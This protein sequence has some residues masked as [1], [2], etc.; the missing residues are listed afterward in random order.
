MPI[1]LLLLGGGFAIT[2]SIAFWR[3]QNKTEPNKNKPI[4]TTQHQTLSASHELQTRQRIQET[5]HGLVVSSVAMGVT[6]YARL[7]YAPLLWV[8][9]PLTLYSSISIFSDTL[10]GLLNKRKFRSSV[11]D[12][13][14]VVGTLASGYYFAAT[15]IN[16]IHFLGQKLL[17]KT[18]D[19]ARKKF[20]QLFNQQPR[21]VCLWQEDV[22]I[23]VSYESIEAGDL[24]VINTG[25]II[26][27][28]GKIEAG[29][30]S[31]DQQMLTGQA[32]PQEKTIGDSVLATTLLTTG[33]LRIQVEKAGRDTVAAHIDQRLINTADYKASVEA[34]SVTTADKLTWPTLALSGVAL[35]TLGPVSAITVVTCN[36][37]NAVLIIPPLGVLNYMKLADQQGILIKD[38]RSLELLNQVDTIVFDK[39]G[40]L[41]LKQ[42]EVKHIHSWQD[43]DAQGIL[44]LAATAEH[45]QSHPAARAIQQAASTSGLELPETDH[46]AY[47]AGYGIKG[48]IDGKT[49]HVGGLR[50]MAMETMIV[51][52]VVEQIEKDGHLNG[53]SLVYVAVDGEISG[54]VELQAS[55]R[56]EAG[57]LILALRQRGL[58]IYIMSGD[59]EKPTQKIAE[60]LAIP[61]FFADML[62]ED[63]AR[64]IE[65]LQAEGKSVCFIGDGLNDTIAMKKAQV[66]ISFSGAST[67][68][69]HTADIV[70]MENNLEKLDSLLDF[71][72]DF[73]KDVR[74]NSA[75]ALA[76]GALS[77]AGLLLF[78][79]SLYSALSLYVV[80]LGAG[81]M[82]TVLPLFRSRSIII[83][84]DNYDNQDKAQDKDIDSL[85][86]QADK[87]I[88]KYAFGSSLTGFIPIPMLDTLGLLSVQ[89]TMLY[90]LCK[91]YGVAFSL[92]LAKT[93]LTTLMGRVA[94]GAAAPI[95]GSALKIFPGVGTLLGGAGMATLGSV[96]TYAM[97]KVFQQH[98]EQGGTL[99]DLDLKKAKDAFIAELEKAKKRA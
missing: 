53:N 34:Q 79:L 90:R 88:K 7:F 30:G 5:N 65:K 49:V 61:H 84:N 45:R 22:E 93:L 36:F 44:R 52:K 50:F 43:L 99:E 23:D 1:P 2:G 51:P 74:T 57:N 56:P 24:I 55:V 46:A 54:A 8:S 32:Q 12:S 69:T 16:G 80:T 82:N 85:S 21:K 39:T 17:L 95:A 73:E 67:A 25:E 78:R 87:I 71:S 86:Q 4:Q 97:G 3:A 13:M 33:K 38:G 27:F 72:K 76:P 35:G 62:P 6:V 18:E 64:H 81:A 77:I 83:M 58:D 92:K 63:K 75:L 42:P 15:F 91:I 26:P 31:I 70:M 96:S 19:H 94:W 59:H 10:D 47:E 37:S 68:A 28:D 89:R 20:I 98:F 14:A 11:I 41:T 29:V 60:A 9:V 40:T 66:S 48:V